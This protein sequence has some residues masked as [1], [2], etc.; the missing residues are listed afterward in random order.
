M[1]FYY[2]EL[3]RLD[4][5]FGN[6]NRTATLI[7]SL[8]IAAWGFSLF[9][10]WGFWLAL[11][12]FMLLGFCLVQT[13]SRGGLVGLLAGSAALLFF[14]DRPWPRVRWISVLAAL[15]LLSGY[16]VTLSA[17]DRYASSWKGDPSVTNRMELWK[18]VPKMIVDAPQGWGLGHAQEAYM[19]WYQSPEREERFLNLVSLHFT[20]L[21]E[22]NWP[23]RAAYLLLWAFGFFLTWPGKGL[24]ILAVPFGVWTATFFA[25]IF[26]HFSTSWPLYFPALAALLVAIGVRIAKCRWPER[27]VLLGVLASVFVALGLIYCVG[28]LPASPVIQTTASGIILGEGQPEAW[29]FVDQAVVGNSYGKTLRRYMASLVDCPS[30][31]IATDLGK[32][33]V[34]ATVV[35]CGNIPS[36]LGNLAPRRLILLNT[37]L[38]PR[39]L[40]MTPEAGKHIIFGEFSKSPARQAWKG[41]VQIVSGAGDFLPTWPKLVFEHL[42]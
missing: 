13:F 21:A 23:L 30:I 35:L 7:A 12:L 6:P 34:Q 25:G 37:S 14:A 40:E 9:R 41:D 36:D 32:I 5:G 33:P 3:L 19:Q 22:L 2:G 24:R 15:I 18:S 17:A 31:G 29:V 1:N 8:M 16:A 27:R 20:L 4:W 26:T 42:R 39:D 10:R 38:T 28:R 11:G